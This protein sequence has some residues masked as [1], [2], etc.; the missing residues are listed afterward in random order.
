MQV[1]AWG[2][3]VLRGPNVHDAYWL[4]QLRTL[5]MSTQPLNESSWD[6][7]LCE[8]LWSMSQE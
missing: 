1:Q 5:V 2:V 6:A 4:S 7:I 8:I 3:K